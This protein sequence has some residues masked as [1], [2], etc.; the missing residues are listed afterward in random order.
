MTAAIGCLVAGGL[1]AET[2]AEFNFESLYANTQAANVTVGAF[3][4]GAG[5]PTESVSMLPAGATD[6]VTDGELDIASA[7]AFEST[8]TAH[9]PLPM[10][11][12][13]IPA[14][15][16]LRSEKALWD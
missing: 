1:S 15:L 10:G 12:F 14:R 4:A 11:C 5:L 8:P 16:R 9:G 3:V 13:Q 6:S 2:I 7:G